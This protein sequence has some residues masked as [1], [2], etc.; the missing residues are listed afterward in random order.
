MSLPPFWLWV[1]SWSPRRLR[2]RRRPGHPRGPVRADERPR[3]PTTSWST[4]APGTARS[5]SSPA[6]DRRQRR[7]GGRFGRRPAGLAGFARH[8][9]TTG[10]CFWRSTP[11]ATPI[12]LFR[13]HGDHL[14]LQQV[15]ASGGQFPVSI[16]V[17]GELGLRAERRRR[18]LRAGLLA[19]R[20]PPL[21][22]ALLAPL[23]RPGQH[24][25]AR[26]P[27]LAR[28]GRL[29]H[30]TAGDSSSPPR[31]APAPST[32]SGSVHR[33]VLSGSAVSNAPASPVPFAFTFDPVGRLVVVEAAMSHLSTY[34]I[35]PDNSLTGIGSVGRWLCGG[36]LDQRRPRLLLHLQRR[37]RQPQRLHAGL[38]AGLPCWWTPWRPRSQAGVIDSVA[39]PD[40]RFLYVEC[41]GAGELAAFRV[42]HDGTLTLIQTITDCRS[43]SRGS[44]STEERPMALWRP[45][46]CGPPQPAVAALRS[47]PVARKEAPAERRT[48]RPIVHVDRRRP[49]VGWLRPFAG[50]SRP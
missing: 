4:T 25:P 50:I 15:A 17:H 12:S 6:T 34:T 36:L 26:L 30:P 37:Q 9:P 40:Q 16:A 24:Q 46:H 13:V 42:S 21:A 19:G 10:A 8:A 33:G 35:N 41:G 20:R 29:L 39:T 44:P 14:W 31:P 43:P 22:D 45:A 48:R 2:L 7:H 27:A 18:R 11:A 32:S 47:T 38:A 3:A 28:A 23:A 5:P 49:L 1:R